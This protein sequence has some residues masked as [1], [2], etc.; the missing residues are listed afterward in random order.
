MTA[1]VDM[2]PTIFR[3][4]NRR[5]TLILVVS[6][7]SYLVGLVMLTEVF[8][9]QTTCMVLVRTK[10][11]L[12]GGEVLEWGRELVANSHP[13]VLCLQEAALPFSC[14]SCF[15]FQPLLLVPVTVLILLLPRVIAG[16][17]GSLCFGYKFI[18]TQTKPLQL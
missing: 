12:V 3:K 2:Y 5:E 17:L 18:L 9:A 1:L 7:L 10:W 4:K 15:S 16:A 11:D 6:I 8:L 14:R 13:A